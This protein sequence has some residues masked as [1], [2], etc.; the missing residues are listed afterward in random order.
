MSHPAP[1]SPQVQD[2]TVTLKI[3]SP[4]PDV[5]PDLGFTVPNSTTVDELKDQ[6]RDALASRPA[7][8]RLRLIHRGKVLDGS[9]AIGPTV[10]GNNEKESI[11]PI[12][13][14]IRPSETATANLIPNTP[15]AP[16]TGPM[17]PNNVFA[18]T[19]A[20][21]PPVA[22]SMTTSSYSRGGNT[23]TTTTVSSS[24]Q[25]LHSRR[26]FGGQMRGPPTTATTSGADTAGTAGTAQDGE[27][28][29][30]ML[31]ESLRE[32][33]EADVAGQIPIPLPM[34]SAGL[35]NLALPPLTPHTHGAIPPVY[36][37]LTPQMPGSIPPGSSVY[38]LQDALNRPYSILVGPPNLTTHHMGPYNPTLIPPIAPLPPNLFAPPPPAGVPNPFAAQLEHAAA[39][40]A[41]VMRA[42][43]PHGAPH[44]VL[45]RVRNRAMMAHVWLAMKLVVFV[46]LFASNGGWRRI[47]YFGAIAVAIFL[48]QTG[49]A[50][51]LARPLMDAANPPPPAAAAAAAG[52]GAGAGAG[53]VGGGMRVPA[54]DAPG[55]LAA[56]QRGV[57]I[58]L[59]SLVPGLHERHVN[60]VQLAQE[61]EARVRAQEVERREQ[62]QE[63]QQAGEVDGQQGQAGGVGQAEV[64]VVDAVM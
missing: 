12:H 49:L 56:L 38:L 46:V 60:A 26:P 30:R 43:A 24:T 39:L 59:A 27:A 58:F 53:G 17:N 34:P 57:A 54:P 1:P 20:M 48:W 31:R 5:P 41:Q 55:A 10:A 8:A 50:V 45:E 6:I 44:N 42:G 3:M 61:A 11:Y 63:Q 37:P 16:L 22:H 4:S 47:L 18:T 14:V 21:P 2:S 64:E 23:I 9:S 13:L 40:R 19:A 32:M 7:P 62:E 52:A 35:P 28:R 29:R 25:G 33:A 15:A 51:E 36:P